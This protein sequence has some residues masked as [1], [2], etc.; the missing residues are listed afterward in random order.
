MTKLKISLDKSS[1]KT[2]FGVDLPSTHGPKVIESGQKLKNKS[3]TKDHRQRKEKSGP[4]LEETWRT[5]LFAEQH[6]EASLTVISPSPLIRA[7][8]KNCV[9]EN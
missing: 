9:E 8:K 3:I 2:K 7:V 4:R 6:K 5:G 1:S